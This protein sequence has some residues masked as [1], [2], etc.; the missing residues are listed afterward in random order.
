MMPEE[1]AFQGIPFDNTS[2]YIENTLPKQAYPCILPRKDL[3]SLFLVLH[4]DKMTA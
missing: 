2:F 3:F 1:N 4:I